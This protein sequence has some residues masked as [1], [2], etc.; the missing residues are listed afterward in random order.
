MQ[1]HVSGDRTRFADLADDGDSCVTVSCERLVIKGRGITD[2]YVR[3]T[4][5]R[6]SDVFFFPGR[7]VNLI[8]TAKL[9]EMESVFS[10]LFIDL[11]KFLLTEQS[12]QRKRPNYLTPAYRAADLILVREKLV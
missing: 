9:W 1:H 10:S 3:N 4:V 6:L 8:S 2:V 12:R 7:T 11:R 5:L